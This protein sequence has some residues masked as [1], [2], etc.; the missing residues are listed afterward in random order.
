MKAWG[1]RLVARGLLAGA[2]MATLAAVPQAQGD[3]RLLPPDGFR[4]GW[5]KAAPPRVFTSADLYGHINGGAEAFLEIG[6]EQLTVQRY[7]SGPEELTVE[8]YRMTDPA[9]ARG[10]Y[11]AR[12][13]AETRDPALRE[14]HTVNR[15]QLL[16]QRHRYYLIVSNVSGTS[17]TAPMLVKTA[18]EVATRLP[19]DAPVPA[20]DLLPKAGFVS[21]SERILRGGFGLQ[22]IYTLGDGDIL[23]LGGTITAV[24]GDY[25]DAALGPHT[26]IVAEYP[27]EGAAS[28]AFKYVRAN[29]DSYLKP[30]TTADARLVFQDYEKKF[31]AIS[32]AGRRL[33]IVVHLLKPPA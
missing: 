30:V 6:F 17:A 12:C 33:T 23:Q 29:L 15:Q 10:I 32:V 5:A 9:A 24:S 14:R 21:G 19:A 11:L 22:A 26:R 25:R 2:A 3:A 18:A 31:G 8:L 13:G 7:R 27:T 28:S 20:L 16:L 1:L 4:N